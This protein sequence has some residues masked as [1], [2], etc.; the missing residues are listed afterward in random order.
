MGLPEEIWKHSWDG[1]KLS[2]VLICGVFLLLLSSFWIT[3]DVFSDTWIE[4]RVLISV[5]AS[6]I[7]G[8]Y[9]YYAGNWI[10]MIFMITL[11]FVLNFSERE[12]EEPVEI[13]R[14]EARVSV[15][16]IKN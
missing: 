1:L 13:L 15:P 4:N 3:P 5:V 16:V 10:L 7:L 2:Q 12:K 14:T 11:A 6:L 8:V 9:Q